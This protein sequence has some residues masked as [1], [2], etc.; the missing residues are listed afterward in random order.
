MMGRLFFLWNPPINLKV[1]GT[2]AKAEGSNRVMVDRFRTGRS[3]SETG[4]AFAATKLDDASLHAHFRDVQGFLVLAG[5]GPQ[6]GAR[7]LPRIAPN[8]R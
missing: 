2:W 4:S 6:L 1:P 8:L 7:A 3:S 5:A